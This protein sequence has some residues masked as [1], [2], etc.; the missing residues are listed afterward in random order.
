MEQRIFSDIFTF[1][2]N[3]NAT[4]VRTDSRVGSVGVNQPRYHHDVD[5]TPLGILLENKSTNLIA[6]SNNL[7]GGYWSKEGG[8][9]AEYGVLGVSGKKDATRITA[10]PNGNV[11]R[12]ARLLNLDVL[13]EF[14]LSYD[15]KH[16]SGSPL[17]T[18][19][20]TGL[21][22][23][24]GYRVRY[25]CVTGEIVSLTGVTENDVIIE[26]LY[27]GWFS[28]TL[29]HPE[30]SNSQ[31]K[32][33]WLDYQK[34]DEEH[35]I[36]IQHVQVEEGHGRSSRIVTLGE[37]V[38]RERD[39]ISFSVEDHFNPT[40]GTWV[41]SGI[42]DDTS[43]LVGAGF[44][45]VG[46]T[47]EGTF[48]FRY[49][50][51]THGTLDVMGET[52]ELRW[53]DDPP[54]IVSINDVI[55]ACVV[56][57]VEYHRNFMS[58]SEVS[59]LVS[60][61]IDVNFPL[62]N[63][64]VLDMDFSRRRFTWM[65]ADG[66]MGRSND[67]TDIAD[68]RKEGTTFYRNNVGVLQQYDAGEIEYHFADDGTR[69]GIHL[70][71]TTRNDLYPSNEFTGSIWSLIKVEST[72]VNGTSPDGSG[73]YEVISQ[74][75]TS[76]FRTL[77][78]VHRPLDAGTYTMSAF[79]R[80]EGTTHMPIKYTGSFSSGGE[81]IGSF[82]ATLDMDS[83]IV[84]MEE[85]DGQV[86]VDDVGFEEYVNDWYR[87][88]ATF[89]L[90][91]ASDSNIIK[92]ISFLAES[93]IDVKY[94]IWGAQ[95]N[96]GY[97]SPYVPTDSSSVST[98]NTLL[99]VFNLD[100]FLPNGR[101]G[102]VLVEF[103]TTVE[104]DR[105]SGLLEIRPNGG[106]GHAKLRQ[107]IAGDTENDKVVWQFNGTEGTAIG[108]G[109]PADQPPT[110]RSGF[111]RVATSFDMIGDNVRH[112]GA[113][114]GVTG[115]LTDEIFDELWSVGEIYVSALSSEGAFKQ[116]LIIKKIEIYSSPKWHGDLANLTRV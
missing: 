43:A 3:S 76:G 31:I 68:Y 93:P 36:D 14:T 26:E 6:E 100:R 37:V 90:G 54:A 15:I 1:N 92:F 56:S 13:K 41:I 40:E 57:S 17:I 16:V 5:G 48:T 55:G 11:F 8:T 113:I 86:R 102:V 25:N 89:T 51:S 65:N 85:G 108:M 22:S 114:D 53:R 50:S 38:T 32:V 42:F 60:G 4:Y 111:H 28:V 2:R 73:Q 62:T 94:G 107:Y 20:T 27:D 35:V 63:S 87:F 66:T 49:K 70:G 58:D 61:N 83:K 79:V 101:N 103:E 75:D 45:G 18:I 19:S 67:P 29:Y 98:P 69:R 82:S 9:I 116:D 47:G 78:T 106:S 115:S 39:E 72:T 110:A 12:A 96:D 77:R 91:S 97:Y 105:N 34:S 24:I 33:A 7:E 80:N 95:L 59:E 84:S 74:T 104:V 10:P 21:F 99:N 71:S 52:V 23:G 112:Q 88:Y 46:L 44:G 81:V 109:Q 64:K 30:P